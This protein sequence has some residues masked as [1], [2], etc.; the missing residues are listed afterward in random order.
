MFEAEWMENPD[1]M[2]LEPDRIVTPKKKRGF[3]SVDWQHKFVFE[4]L[5]PPAE[6]AIE[7]RRERMKTNL[8]P[9][10]ENI[11]LEIIEQQNR[12]YFEAAIA[13]QR[14]GLAVYIRPGLYDLP[15][16]IEGENV[17]R[18]RVGQSSE[19]LLSSLSQAITLATRKASRLEPK[20]KFTPVTG[21][22]R[23]STDTGPLRLL[24]SKTEFHLI[25]DLPL[26]GTSRSKPHDWLLYDP[27]IY[28]EKLGAFCRLKPGVHL[29]VGD[30]PWVAATLG[31]SATFAK[32]GLRIEIRNSD[33]YFYPR[34][35]TLALEIACLPQ[36]VTK[37]I[38]KMQRGWLEGFAQAGELLPKTEALHLLKQTNRII[39]DEVYRP[40]DHKAQPGALINF[41]PHLTPVIV[42]DL[43][44]QLDNLLL[45]LIQNGL[46]LAL[47]EDKAVLLLLGDFIHPD[48]DDIEEMASS[49]LMIDFICKLKVRF[50]QNV[51]FLRGNHESFSP[52]VAKGGVPQGQ[53]FEHAVRKHRGDKYAEEL[54]RFF[55]GLA[56][57]ARSED[58]IAC[59]A[60]PVCKIVSEETLINLKHHP[61]LAAEVMNGR[62]L[63]PGNPFGYSRSDVRRFRRLMDVGVDTPF[64][65]GHTRI[66]LEDGVWFNT[67]KIPSNHVIYSS[68]KKRFGMVMRIKDTM[69]AMELTHEP[70]IGLTR[71]RSAKKRK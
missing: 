38:R 66:T 10:E 70:L 21:S 23:I 15:H 67:G 26:K 19:T 3:F 13:M 45:V 35:K 27:V 9:V 18:C 36:S 16:R 58:F 59:H 39:A 25:P 32:P 48:S 34:D 8:V 71:I 51:F 42:G 52:D 37:K 7:W 29:A 14:R 60:G 57:M 40:R 53:L 43:H 4:F 12:A 24:I 20:T 46:L 33:L 2:I 1:R 63:K 5:I 50:P 22:I 44:T 64:F 28:P 49:C 31:R 11:T 30:N 68:G 54:S 69:V 6:K 56:L 47:R 55:D 61:V 62:A 65:V 41:P 17:G